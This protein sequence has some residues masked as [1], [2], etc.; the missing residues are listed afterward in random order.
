MFF[1]TCSLF[2]GWSHKLKV[3]WANCQTISSYPVR[4]S[5]DTVSNNNIFFRLFFFGF[6]RF[7][8]YFWSLFVYEIFFCLEQ[9]IYILIH[10]RL[11]ARVSDEKIF[12]RPISR[13]KTTFC[14]DLTFHY[15]TLNV[16]LIV[17]FLLIRDM[18]SS[19]FSLD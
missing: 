19:N 14:F 11:C 5:I 18:S 7:S 9:K 16:D 13:N 3:H 1:S 10:I 17:T 6:F 4:F 12:T 8:I 2:V 15:V